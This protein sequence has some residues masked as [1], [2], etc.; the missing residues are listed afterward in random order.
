MASCNSN[1]RLSGGESVADGCKLIVI[2][3]LEVW[4]VRLG[5][6]ATPEKTTS[7]SI[8]SDFLVFSIN[9]FRRHHFLVDEIIDVI[10][11]LVK[12]SNIPGNPEIVIGITGS[13]VRHDLPRARSP[14]RVKFV[15]FVERACA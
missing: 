7:L 9:C 6:I 2:S 15:L 12:N 14:L 8:G 3:H 13:C 11:F 4:I 5:P 1:D 10:A